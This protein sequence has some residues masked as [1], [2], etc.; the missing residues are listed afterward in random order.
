MLISA[1]NNTTFPALQN[2]ELV[3]PSPCKITEENNDGYWD[4][5]ERITLVENGVNI[6]S[7]ECNLIVKIKYETVDVEIS[8]LN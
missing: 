6:C 2:P 1:L 5:N 7:V 8:Y 3:V 4:S